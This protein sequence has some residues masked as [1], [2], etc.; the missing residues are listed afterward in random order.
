MGALHCL[1]VQENPPT[2]TCLKISYHFLHHP[3]P[4]H[5]IPISRREEFIATHD[6]AQG[7]GIIK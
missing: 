7:E 5:T 6:M 4:S 1:K 2:S 3:P